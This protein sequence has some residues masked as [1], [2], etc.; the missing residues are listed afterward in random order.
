MAPRP[1]DPVGRQPELERLGDALDE[2]DRGTTTCLAVEGEP[3]IGK[4]RLLAALR[5]RAED[6]RHLVLAGSAAEFERDLPFGVWVDALDAYVASQDLDARE[7]VD[8]EL[9]GDLAGVLPSLR[10][11]G[12]ARGDE[13]HRVQRAIRALLELIARDKPLVLVLDDLH[14]SDAASIDALVAL[15][16]RPPAGRVLLALGCRSGQAPSRLAAALVA[17]SV[18][19]VELGPLSEEDSAELAGEG[20]AAAQRAAIY[21]QSGG[22]PFYTLQLARAAGPP[23]RSATGDR[24]ALDAGVPRLVAAALVEELDGLSTDA[25]ALVNGGAIAG[26]P[27]E[28]E[29]AYAIAELEPEAGI[30]A[31]DELLDARL[32]LPTDVPR[33]FRFRH[34]LVRRAVYESTKGGWRLAAHA[35]AD[36]ALAH[37]GASATARAHHVEQSATRG[38]AAAIALLLQAGDANAPRAPATAAGWY[39]AALRLIPE[40]DAPARLR[41]LMKLAQMQQSTG[42]LVRCSATLLEA[43]ELVPG[44][45]VALRLRLTSACASCE[46]FLGRH[47]LAERRLVATLNTLPEGSREAVIVLLDLA[48]GAFFTL[49]LE[50]MCDMGRRGVAAARALGEPA[51][52]GAAAAVL[53]H[54]CA[55]AGLVAEAISN[56]DEAGACL[57]DLSGDTLA[58]HLDTV[59]RLAWAEYLIERFD[60]SIRHAARGVAVAR[61][62]G[63]GQFAQ[64]ILSAQALSTAIRGDL[65]AATALQEE[66]IETAE[67]AANDYLTSGVLT[68]TANIAMATGD[69]DRARRAAER[70]ADCVADVEGGHLAAMAR[71]RLAVTLRELGASAADTEELVAAAG[72]WELPRITGAWRV[73]YLEA[74]TRM[75]VDGGRA[76]E[77]AACAALAEATAAGL[78]LPLAGALAQRARARVLLAG[79]RGA[80]AAGLALMSAAAADG[81]GAPVEA[82]RSR[83]LAARALSA[84]ADR[85]QAIAL[86]RAAE[87]ELDERGALRDRGEARR[88][89]RRLGARAEPR[90]PAGAADGG[91]SSLSVREREVA[92][93]IT[94]RKTNKEV[95]GELFLS[96]KTVESHLR[97]IFAKLGATSRVDVARAV[98]RAQG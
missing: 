4:T 96:E 2:L 71:V 84:A 74:L 31:L 64:L 8:P 82:A 90:G 27:F 10:G 83:V 38:D 85:A 12:A 73:Q 1:E 95:A 48:T 97:N 86:L 22:N 30:V 50:R 72:G 11:D 3:G 52:V 94:A 6:C 14:W 77:A 60:D 89:L 13:R 57:D 43:I 79:G 61:A 56:A 47:E 92:V 42:D 33:R 59:S 91:L 40:E 15:L 49:E 46:N 35:R 63:Q 78:G 23:S 58:L 36:R 9:L 54:G 25:R 67:L 39:A 81:A 19:L 28:P 88:E 55:N 20:W 45:D 76:E 53:A 37:E 69:L 32:L 44:D 17:P 80:E 93:L 70:S 98:E 7:D 24:L 66:A 29:L 68:A 75:E 26:D 5:G 18:T 87:R 41:T 34:P 62:T 51:L 65:S 21:E 16:R